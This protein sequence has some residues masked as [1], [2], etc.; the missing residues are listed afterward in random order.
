MSV[1]D[2]LGTMQKWLWPIL[3]Y[4]PTIFWKGLRKNAEYLMCCH[5]RV[6]VA[7]ESASNNLIQLTNRSNAGEGNRRSWPISKTGRT[8]ENHPDF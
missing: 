3:K 7:V 2:E 1:N 5:A 6:I 8:E 4:C